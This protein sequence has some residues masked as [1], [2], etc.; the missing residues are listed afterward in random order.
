MASKAVVSLQVPTARPQNS[1]MPTLLNAQARKERPWSNKRFPKA[2]NLQISIPEPDQLQS[3]PAEAVKVQNTFIHV[4]SPTPASFERFAQSCPSRQIGCLRDAFDEET[5]SEPKQILCLEE[6]LF[7]T[8]MPSTPEPPQVGSLGMSV[9]AGRPCFQ[10]I[11]FPG[12]AHPML[13]NPE[14]NCL[15]MPPQQLGAYPQEMALG[16]MA[17]VMQPPV[18]SEM[19]S[20]P[21]MP[22]Q[23]AP[24]SA[25]LPS[26]GSKDHGTGECKPCAFLHVRGCD[27]GAM[28]KF[29][30]L[31][32]A[33]EKKRRQKAKK[34]AFR[35]GA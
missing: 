19:V 28:C 22:L 33:G 23:S 8:P 9:T 6:V 5:S 12:P 10:E 11:S 4:T 1:E 27:N 30:H 26:V 16:Q 21:P 7:E 3:Y 29:C 2:S 25:E 17:N 35:G 24:G 31:C 14:L 15:P 20:M 32:D 18:F 34:A 13:G